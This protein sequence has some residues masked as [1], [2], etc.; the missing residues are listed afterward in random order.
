MRYVEKK[1]LIHFTGSLMQKEC[2]YGS[3][4]TKNGLDLNLL[5][6]LTL[7]KLNQFRVAYE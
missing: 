3:I 4:F 1:N 7:T 5:V 2:F 6:V